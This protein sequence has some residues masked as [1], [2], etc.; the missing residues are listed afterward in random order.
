MYKLTSRKDFLKKAKKFVKNNRRNRDKLDKTISLLVAN[1]YNLILKT[2]RVQHRFA[3][4]AFSSRITGD[5]RV[6]WD[7]THDN[8]NTI[9]LIDLGGHSGKNKVYR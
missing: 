8:Q 6:I 9:I 7:F 4:K 1:P 3:G 5:I 2:H